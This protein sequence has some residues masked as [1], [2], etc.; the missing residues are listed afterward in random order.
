MSQSSC[1]EFA[2]C[3]SKESTHLIIGRL[4]TFAVYIGS[5]IYTP[6]LGGVEERFNVGPIAALLGM[7][8]YV[9][10]CVQSILFQLKHD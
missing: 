2:K 5:S 1:R 7:S 9:L 3:Q 10:A 8:L 6:G 4:Y